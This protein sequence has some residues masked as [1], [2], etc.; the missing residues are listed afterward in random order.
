MK[1][2]TLS[3][4]NQ[5][6]AVFGAATFAALV[7]L[8]LWP[9]MRVYTAGYDLR[10]AWQVDLAAPY[11]DVETSLIGLGI[12][13]QSPLIAQL[14]S[15]LG[16]LPWI[17]AQLVFLAIQLGA[18]VLIAGRRWPYVV[19][20][21]G[22]F[23]NLGLGNVDLLMGA[24]VVAGF[25]Y[26]GTWAF[27]FLTKVSPGIGVLWF[28]IRG[29]WR[30]LAIALGTT[31]AIVGASFALAPALWFDWFDAL[32]TMAG[33]PQGAYP[34]LALRVAVALVLLALAAR[35]NRRWLLPVVCWLAVPNPWFVTL[36]VL[37][38]SIALWRPPA[39]FEPRLDHRTVT[40]AEPSP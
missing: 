38:G 29:E 9:I 18:I 4:K 5:R 34:P 6:L 7:D 22:V 39:R 12:F 28:A 26:P 17:Q 8:W 10:A 27:L 14:G 20:F 2:L 33:L 11:G 37:G 15:L 24:A 3:P 16:L 30:Q 31:A 35:T 32:R 36:A 25:R 13:R 1:P 23:W 40:S 19:L 21:P